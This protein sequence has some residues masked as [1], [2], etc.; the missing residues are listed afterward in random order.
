MVLSKLKI[1]QT[2]HRQLNMELSE[3]TIKDSIGE[4]N[5][6]IERSILED[7]SFHIEGLGTFFIKPAYTHPMRSI[8]TDTTEAKV[9]ATV[10]FTPHVHL[11]ELMEEKLL[12]FEKTLDS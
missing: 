1:S 10:L 8:W 3:K 2:I 6:Y 4:I 12:R 11:K 9:P 7:G 5:R